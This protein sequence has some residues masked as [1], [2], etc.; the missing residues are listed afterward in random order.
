MSNVKVRIE[1]ALEAKRIPLKTYRWKKNPPHIWVSGEWLVVS[2][3][4]YFGDHEWRLPL[5]EVA[6]VDARDPAGPVAEDHP[7][8]EHDYSRRLKREQLVPYLATTASVAPPT[9]GLLFRRPQRVPPVRA[10]AVRNPMHP[11]PFGA[12]ATKSS[13]GAYLDG[14][15]LREEVPGHLAAIASG[16]GIELATGLDWFERH[17]ETRP[18]SPGENHLPPASRMVESAGLVS[19]AA[20]GGLWWLGGTPSL[21]SALGRASVFLILGGAA[22]A[23][24]SDRIATRRAH[25]SARQEAHRT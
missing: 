9:S 13:E 17:R 16:H 2:I 7:N 25:E 8:L 12:K 18:E 4:T 20:G 3:P 19:A 21:G 15:L 11:F 14:V 24:A 23:A 1:T 22:I 6:I 10:S 5:D